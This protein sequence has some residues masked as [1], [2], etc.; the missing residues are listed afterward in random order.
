MD[1]EGN[2]GLGELN[3]LAEMDESFNGNVNGGRSLIQSRSGSMYEP[4]EELNNS[5]RHGTF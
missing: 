3:E 5:S 4:R 1:N 2:A